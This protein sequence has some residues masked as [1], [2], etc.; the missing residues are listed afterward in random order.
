[1]IASMDADAIPYLVTLF[2]T[3]SGSVNWICRIGAVNSTERICFD[4]SYDEGKS[5]NPYNC[6]G[7]I[8][9]NGNAFTAS[10]VSGGPA[11]FKGRV[12]VNGRVRVYV[13]DGTGAPIPI[14]AQVASDSYYGHIA[15]KDWFDYVIREEMSLE[16][17]LKDC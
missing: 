15:A 7:V 14:H 13:T 5:W 9:P 16:D 17:A 1:M 8:G 2:N 6:L 3:T 4:I 12:E 11:I 10:S